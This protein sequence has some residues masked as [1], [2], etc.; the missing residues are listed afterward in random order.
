MLRNTILSGVLSQIRLLPVVK[1]PWSNTVSCNLC[2]QCLR[3]RPFAPR[4]S[5]QSAHYT[6]ACNGGNMPADSS[7]RKE[8]FYERIL[9]NYR[10]QDTGRISIDNLETVLYS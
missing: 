8:N 2:F 6:A 4:P 1:K 9:K 7:F 5:R 3:G 10:S